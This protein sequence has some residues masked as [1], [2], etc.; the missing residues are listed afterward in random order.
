MSSQTQELFDKLKGEKAAI[1]AQSAPLREQ[2]DAVIQQMDPLTRQ[3]AALAD[4]IAA[5]ERP[6]L[7]ELDN[8]ISGLAIALGAKRMS[9]PAPEETVPPVDGE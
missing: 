3:A 1:E 2:R 7:A 6:H 5:I 4:Q 8:E 9:E